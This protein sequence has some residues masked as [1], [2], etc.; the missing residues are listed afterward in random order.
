MSSV[1][2]TS[3]TPMQPFVQV[4]GCL[5]CLERDAATSKNDQRRADTAAAAKGVLSRPRQRSRR[6]AAA[7]RPNV[8]T[9]GTADGGFLFLCEGTTH[10]GSKEDTMA[11]I[12]TITPNQPVTYTLLV[13][14]TLAPNSDE[15]LQDQQAIRDEA[16]TW[17]TSFDA[18][19]HVN[20]R[21]AD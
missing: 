17:L 13:I 5:S 4:S 19:V 9:P 20:V 15:H 3:A 2:P 8:L 14:F 18:T 6:F 7:S 21:K 1:W 11:T 12:A 10:R 16:E